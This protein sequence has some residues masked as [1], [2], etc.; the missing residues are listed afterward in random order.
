MGGAYLLLVLVVMLVIL[1]LIPQGIVIGNGI[2]YSL[3][4]WQ[5]VLLVCLTALTAENLRAQLLAFKSSSEPVQRK[6]SIF[7]M[8]GI[9]ILFLFS[10]PAGF[11]AFSHLPLGHVG[12][13]IVASLWTYV[14]VGLRGGRTQQ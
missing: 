4:I 1:D 7:I 9:G 13:L 3:G 14:L 11:V 5:I 2:S 12:N 6:Q 8:T 10:L